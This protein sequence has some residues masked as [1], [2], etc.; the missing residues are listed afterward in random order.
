MTP[1]QPSPALLDPR[2]LPDS[3]RRVWTPNEWIAQFA[4]VSRAYSRALVGTTIA[5]CGSFG[6]RRRH[7]L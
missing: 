7:R 6:E 1:R 5:Y 2:D 3:I 4:K